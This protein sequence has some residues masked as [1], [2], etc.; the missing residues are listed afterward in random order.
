MA[1]PRVYGRKAP[2]PRS[3]RPQGRP[4]YGP[5]TRQAGRE[6]EGRVRSFWQRRG[7]EVGRDVA[8]AALAIAL[9]FAL[10]NRLAMRQEAAEAARAHRAEV[11][12]NTRFVRER[13]GDSSSQKP[14]SGLNLR[15]ASLEALDLGC[16]EEGGPTCAVFDRADLSDAALSLADLANASLH[17]T[18]LT[19]VQAEITRFDQADLSDADLAGANLSKSFF[20]RADLVRA[21]FAGANLQQASM[22]GAQLYEA[23]FEN[24][25]LSYADLRGADFSDAI[26]VRAGTGRDS[27]PI[28]EQACHDESTLWP[29]G[30]EP[31]P[32]RRLP[33]ASLIP[34]RLAASTN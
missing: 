16:Q 2:R 27:S 4:P 31:P 10:D 29:P 7:F 19:G 34:C 18:N 15:G 13:A 9:T 5:P 22:T 17:G 25:D 32:I 8:I 20:R 28:L 23:V 6:P 12:E 1:N 11:L 14:F 21:N 3:M 24:A 30:F 33:A 26:F